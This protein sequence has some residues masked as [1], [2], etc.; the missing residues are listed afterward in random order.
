MNLH[1]MKQNIFSKTMVLPIVDLHCYGPKQM[2][3]L[4][5]LIVLLRKLYSLL[6]MKAVTGNV[7]WILFWS[8][9]EILLIGQQVKRRLS[10]FFLSLLGTSYQLFQVMWWFTIR[11]CS[12]MK[13]FQKEKMKTYADPKRIAKPTELKAGGRGWRFS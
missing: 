11:W 5:K 1:L 8:A 6:L 13:H 9:T 4:S 12:K 7:N 10:C 2:G 3:K